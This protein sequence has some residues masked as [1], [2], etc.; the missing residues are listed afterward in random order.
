MHLTVQELITRQMQPAASR[1]LEVDTPFYQC[2][3]TP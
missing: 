2:Y 3:C 1:H